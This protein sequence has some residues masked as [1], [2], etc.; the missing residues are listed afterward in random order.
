M[1]AFEYRGRSL[2]GTVVQGSIQAQTEDDARRLLGELGVQV[3]ST[4]RPAT[5][6][7]RSLG[8]A[9]FQAFNQQLAQ[10]TRAG[11]PV[12]TGLR[13]VA[14]D[15]S[16]G[17]LRSAVEGV[18]V[19]LDA[20]RT[21]PQAIDKYRHAFPSLYSELIDAG[22]R[23]NNLPALL[24]NIGRHTE[25]TAGLRWDLIRAASYPVIVFLATVVVGAFLGGLVLPQLA[26]MWKP[27]SGLQSAISWNR[28]ARSSTNY[29]E[30]LQIITQI[31]IVAGRALPWIA[32]VLIALVVGSI[33][34]WPIA[35]KLGLDRGIVDR[36]FLRLPL[37]GRPL[38]WAIAAR[39]CDAARIAVESGLDLPRAAKLAADSIGSPRLER[40]TQKIIQAVSAGADLN[41]LTKLDLLPATVPATM[42][43][44]TQSGMLAD[45][46][47]TLSRL[48]HDNAHARAAVIPIILTPILLIFVA[49]L[50]GFFIVAIMSPLLATLQ[51]FG[52]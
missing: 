14:Q 7:V 48:Y 2:Q 3:D 28:G 26:D 46:L 4:N 23:A 47:A 16:S 25:M 11:M 12:E 37:I 41:T 50:I 40:D 36:I 39:W 42:Q 9:D 52:G 17:R 29:A 1:E 32:G 30:R 34:L 35:R 19:E 5:P 6:I 18:V 20:G 27:G 24:L 45:A 22:I 13:I 43:I 38:R 33:A 31:G 8:S 10:L 21:L 51:A 44:A 15:M 49:G